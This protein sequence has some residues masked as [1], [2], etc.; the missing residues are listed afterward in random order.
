MIDESYPR[1]K[2]AK[3]EK[4]KLLNYHSLILFAQ[5]FRHG[6]SCG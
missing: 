3:Y 6:S 2:K 4:M 5:I 1:A